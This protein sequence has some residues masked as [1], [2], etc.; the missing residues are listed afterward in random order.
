[1]IT[2]TEHQ[3]KQ[4][5]E[6]DYRRKPPLYAWKKDMIGSTCIR[7]YILDG[8]VVIRMTTLDCDQVKSEYDSTYEADSDLVQ[9]A[10][11]IYIPTMEDFDYWE[12]MGL[13]EAEEIAKLEKQP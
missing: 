12:K 8:K 9:E 1:M 7:E 13:D 2:I 11:Y 5:I 10:S 3:F 4:V 6:L